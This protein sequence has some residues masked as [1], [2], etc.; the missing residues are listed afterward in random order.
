[1]YSRGELEDVTLNGLDVEEEMYLLKTDME[2]IILSEIRYYARPNGVTEDDE[3]AIKRAIDRG[4]RV[5]LGNLLFIGR[6]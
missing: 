3:K 5:T 1:M 2:D 6:K 4:F